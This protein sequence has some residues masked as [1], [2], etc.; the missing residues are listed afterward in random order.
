[1][2][3]Y[4][5]TV[6]IFGTITLSN[7]QAQIMIGSMAVDTS[8]VVGKLFVPWEIIWGPDNYIWFT[9][10]DGKVCRLDP[11]AKTYKVI[12]KISDVVQQSE[13]GLLGMALHPNFQDSAYVYLVY[14]YLSGSTIKERLVRY[15]YSPDTLTGRVIL[16]DNVSGNGNHNGSRLIIT[17]DRKIMMTTGD[18]QNTSLSQN[19]ASISGKILRLNLDGTVPSDN[20]KSGNL[21]WSKG[22]RNAQGL[23]LASNGILYSSEHGPNNDD[24]LNIIKKGRNYGWPTVEGFCNGATEIQFCNDSNVVQPIYAWTP[25]LAVA[26]IDYYNS[27]AIPEWKNCILMTN[28]KE[29]DFRVLQ[30]NTAGDSITKSTTYFNNWFG[31]LRD[32]CIAPNGDVYIATSNRDGRGVSPFPKPIDDRIIRIR[33]LSTIGTP[34]LNSEGATV[35]IHPNPFKDQTSIM[36]SNE[37]EGLNKEYDFKICNLLGEEIKKVK[38]KNKQVLTFYKDD[39]A[40]GVYL[41][42]VFI[43]DKLLNSGKLIIN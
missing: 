40:K 22:H 30:L 19:N 5:L 16:L 10:R 38:L 23:V 35:K 43:K 39:L 11:V 24:E 32:V 12:L 34:Q 8:M 37:N 17:P 9:Q 7:I 42:Q 18:A 21:L 14:N 13:S 27:N 36:I 3:K 28:L 33:G 29:S 25:T 20:P 31:R 4:I 41:Y 6:C 15:T 2:K 26:G 1:M